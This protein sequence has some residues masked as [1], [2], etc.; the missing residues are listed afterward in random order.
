MAEQSSSLLRYRIKFIALV[1]VFLSPF[2]AGWLAFYVF[3]LRPE[4]SHFGE[5][6]VP[7]QKID[8]SLLHQPDGEVYKSQDFDKWTF[9]LIRRQECGSDCQ[10]SLY[11]QRQMRIALGRDTD[12]VRNILLFETSL[13][14]EMQAFMKD[15]PELSVYQR[16]DQAMLNQFVVPDKAD[17]HELWYLVDPDHNL[18]MVYPMVNEIREVMDDLRRL[19]KISQ[20]G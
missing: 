3:E 13:P 5:L 6:V 17:Q 2:I 9:V 19:L 20:I 15:Y 16:V 18:M 1:L 14:E 4:S 8:F 7:V 11:Y 10:Q 12:R